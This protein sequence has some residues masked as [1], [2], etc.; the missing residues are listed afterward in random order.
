MNLLAVVLDIIILVFCGL[1]VWVAYLLWCLLGK[2]GI[3]SWFLLA[4]IYGILL[5]VC[6]LISDLGLL[7]MDSPR[8]LALP[9]YILLALGLYGLFKQVRKAMS[10]PPM[11]PAGVPIESIVVKIE[12]V[13]VVIPE[14]TIK[15]PGKT[16]VLPTKNGKS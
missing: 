8:Y 2:K 14:A 15:I 12:E 7:G 5:R 4:F 16:I 9:L 3:T 10:V 6:S 11:I 13:E 1:G